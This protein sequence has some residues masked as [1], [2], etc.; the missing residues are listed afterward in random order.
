M[1]VIAYK[2]LIINIIMLV[3]A[4]ME[5]IV[6]FVIMLWSIALIVQVKHNV[7]SVQIVLFLINLFLSIIISYYNYLMNSKN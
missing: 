3:P 5:D 7:I 6:I 2:L 4:L 1:L